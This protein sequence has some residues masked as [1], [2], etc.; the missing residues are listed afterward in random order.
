MKFIFSEKKPERHKDSDSKLVTTRSAPSMRLSL[1][2]IFPEQ[3]FSQH[4]VN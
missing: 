2:K 1:D 3:N 4:Q